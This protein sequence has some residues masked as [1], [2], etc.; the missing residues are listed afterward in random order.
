MSIWKF[1]DL[2]HAFIQQILIHAYYTIGTLVGARNQ[3][4]ES[5]S[6]IKIQNFING[7]FITTVVSSGK[8]M[9]TAGADLV[10]DWAEQLRMVEGSAQEGRAW[11]GQGLPDPI[12]GIWSYC[13]WSQSPLKG[14]QSESLGSCSSP[15]GQQS[16]LPAKSHCAFLATVLF[17][18]PPGE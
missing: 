4:R 16:S 10:Q 7:F 15:K 2:I 5:F 8:Q 1:Q 17:L 3:D 18:S 11:T 12:R 9:R 13:E 14:S 6:F